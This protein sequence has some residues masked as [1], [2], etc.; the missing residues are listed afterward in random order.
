MLRNTFNSTSF[1][2]APL[3][4]AAIFYAMNRLGYNGLCRYNL[5]RKFSVPWGKR[6]QFSLDIQKVD[7]L[8]FRLS[9]VELK[10]ADF[11]SDAGVCRWW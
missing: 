9:S 4:R 5:K 2:D 7:Y 8:S 11:W 3:Q 10:T 6:Y 1:D